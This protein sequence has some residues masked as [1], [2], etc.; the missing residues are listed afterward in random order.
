MSGDRETANR[1]T[2]GLAFTLTGL[3]AIGAAIF[4]GGGFVILGGVVAA[5][6]L[7]PSVVDTPMPPESSCERYL[8]ECGERAP[9]LTAEEPAISQQPNQAQGKQRAASVAASRKARR[10]G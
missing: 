9:Q 6:C 2:L 7:A 4:I 1:E 10:S 8:R 5:L 3:A